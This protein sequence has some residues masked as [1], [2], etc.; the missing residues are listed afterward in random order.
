M[1]FGVLVNTFEPFTMKRNK[2]R[3]CNWGGYTQGDDGDFSLFLWDA[4]KNFREHTPEFADL[5]V[6]QA[7]NAPLGFRRAGSQ[8]QANTF[9]GQEVSLE[10]SSAPWARGRGLAG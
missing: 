6:L 9:N 8:A 1:A 3:C 7:G 4:Y 2:I 10:I 5:A